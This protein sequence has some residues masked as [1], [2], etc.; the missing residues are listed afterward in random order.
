V[1]IHVAES[2]GKITENGTNILHDGLVAFRYCRAAAYTSPD[3]IVS[4]E[5]LRADRAKLLSRLCASSPGPPPKK[6]STIVISI[7]IQSVACPYQRYGFYLFATYYNL[8]VILA[9]SSPPD[10]TEGTLAWYEQQRRDAIE[11]LRGNEEEEEEE[12]K[13]S[14]SAAKSS[15]PNNEEEQQQHSN[16]PLRTPCCYYLSPAILPTHRILSARTVHG[17]VAVVRQLQSVDAMFDYETAVQTLLA[18]FGHPVM[19]YRK[20]ERNDDTPATTTIP[21]EF[22]R[23]LL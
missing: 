10:G 16:A 20:E 21:S 13:K 2:T 23:M 15:A 11:V 1:P 12:T 22:G 3:A 18:R 7:P 9:Q 4:H 6:G 17:R 8:F 19:L 5:Q 14:P